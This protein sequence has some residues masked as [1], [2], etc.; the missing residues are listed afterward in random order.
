ML[1]IQTC[2]DF[3]ED[4]KSMVESMGILLCQEPYLIW[5]EATVF[6]PSRFCLKSSATNMQILHPTKPKTHPSSEHALC[7]VSESEFALSLVAVISI[8]PSR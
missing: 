2:R 5:D 1:T 3:A 8:W 6:V 4:L 7:T